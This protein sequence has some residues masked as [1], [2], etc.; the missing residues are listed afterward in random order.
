MSLL[1][2][3]RPMRKGVSVI[4][5]DADEFEDGDDDD[6]HADDVKDTVIHCLVGQ[7]LSRNRA[8]HF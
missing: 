1:S 6:D 8:L 3:A 4:S 7:G 2:P 5:P